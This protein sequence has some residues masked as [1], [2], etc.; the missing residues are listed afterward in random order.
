MLCKAVAMEKNE[1]FIGNIRLSLAECLINEGMKAEA[2]HELKLY[3]DNYDAK[4]WKVKPNANL[5]LISV[6][7]SHRQK[8]IK[9]F[10]NS[11]FLLQMNMPIHR[12]H[13]QN[14][15]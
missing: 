2:C 15:C 12:Y 13:T 6:R 11:T 10:I 8:T 14:C 3:K 9:A 7:V 5:Y 1:D 4:G